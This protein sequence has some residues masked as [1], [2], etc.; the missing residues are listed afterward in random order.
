MCTSLAARSVGPLFGRNLDLEYSFGEQVVITPRRYPFPF[1]LREP[2]PQHYALIGMA[3]VANNYPLYAEA[4]NE[5]GLY[6]AGLN[7]P[8]NAYYPPAEDGDTQAVTPYELIPLILGRCADLAQARQILEGLCLAAIPF[9]PGYPLAPLHWH[10]ADASGCLV[11]EATRD[12]IHLYEDPAGVLTNNPPYPLQLANL[13]NYMHLSA[14]SP[15]NRFAPGLDLHTVGQGMGAIGLPGDW[16]PQSRFVRA[17]FLKE[18]ALWGDAPEEAV[19]EFFHILDGVAMVRGS[20]ITP[21]GKPDITTYSCCIDA[22]TGIYYYKTYGNNQISAVHL[23]GADLEGEQ[24]SCFP[25]IAGQQI[26]HVNAER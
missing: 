10:I 17:C 16:S 15:E 19:G 4:M 3:T 26:C 23:H 8:G 11:M 21:E 1:R 22:S 20:V 5:K 6:M 18:N 24:L 25:L 9:A 13:N 12:G 7:F 14:R 2:L